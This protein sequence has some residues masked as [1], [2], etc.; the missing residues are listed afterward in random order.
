M[1]IMQWVKNQ[2]MKIIKDYDT[3][4]ANSKDEDL[5]HNAAIL[6]ILFTIQMIEIVLAIFGIAYVFCML[7]IIL[8][9]FV[10][11]F[12]LNISY[13]TLNPKIKADEFIINNNFMPNF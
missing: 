12:V 11:D 7:W 2:Q 5:T 3:K 1:A 10:E 4:T 8:T 6:Y 13:R 9:E